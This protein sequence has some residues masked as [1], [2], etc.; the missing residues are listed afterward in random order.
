MSVPDAPIITSI[1]ASYKQLSVYFTPPA[2]NGGTD[3]TAYSYTINNRPYVSVSST[4]SPIDISGLIPGLTYTVSLTCTNAV[5]TSIPSAPV[6]A[7]L[8][9]T[10]SFEKAM[11]LETNGE[12]V[13]LTLRNELNQTN[14]YK[15]S[16]DG[17]HWTGHTFPI[18]GLTKYNPYNSKWTGSHF[19][20]C[21]DITNL[22]GKDAILK[23]TDG[24]EFAP[25]ATNTDYPMFDIETNHEHRNTITF[26]VDT[27]LV[28]G[29]VSGDTVQLAHTHDLGVSWESASPSPFSVSANA[30]CW[31]GS[32]W[33]AVGTGTNTIA[34]SRID[35][36]IWTGCGSYIFS[37]SGNSVAWSKEQ[38]LIV[39]VGSGINS[40]AYSPDGLYWFGCGSSIFS[41]GTSVAWN[42]NIWVAV[43]TGGSA[44]IAY[45][46]NGKTWVSSD[47]VFASGASLVSW[48][49]TQW[50]VYG[51]DPSYNIATSADGIH[52]TMKS[53]P[54]FPS[55]KHISN[56]TG[57][58]RISGSTVQ[59]SFDGIVWT[60]TTPISGMSSPKY[61]A[62]NNST[63]GIPAISP[64]TVAAGEGANTL[65]YSPDGIFWTGTQSRVFSVRANSAVWNGQIWVAVGTGTCSIATSYDGISWTPVYNSDA[66]LTEIYDVAWNGT[67]FVAVG[68]STNQITMAV[69][70]DGKT[71]STISQSVFSIRASGIAWTGRIWVAYG[72]GG[73][74]TAIS[75]DVYAQTWSPTSL[76]I[77][78]A[79]NLPVSNPSATITASSFSTDHQPINAFNQTTAQSWRSASSTYSTMT[80]KYVGSNSTTVA[81]G[82]TI[83][84]EWIQIQFPSPVILNYSCITC[85]L[86]DPSGSIPK[87][88]YIV[89]SNDGTA[90]D[91]VDTHFST[92][93]VSPINNSIYVYPSSLFYN[94]T[95]YVYYRLVCASSFGATHVSI[96][97]W[98]LFSKT[99]GSD[100][101][102]LRMKPIIT[103]NAI[104]YASTLLSLDN[105]STKLQPI[106]WTSLA[107]TVYT[108][109][110]P[111]S[112]QTYI[113]RSLSGI[114]QPLSATCF[115]GENVICASISGDIIYASPN[116]SNTTYQFDQS[117]NQTTIQSNLSTIY[118]LCYNTRFIIAGG[119]S[120][121]YTCMKPGVIP[122][123]YT[124]NASNIMSTVYCV[125]SNSGYGPTYIPNAIYL[126]TGE[127]LSV[128]SPKTYNPSFAS[129]TSIS[130][131]MCKPSI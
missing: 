126:Q 58:F 39:A 1:F 31:T 124:T 103:K 91:L 68:E 56:S 123:W 40:I 113:L 120:I 104:L 81:L 107:N 16:N 43:G 77:N 44:S 34:V 109:D 116:H 53:A 3:I 82:P 21:G 14:Q 22:D 17:I 10:Y 75:T 33:V 94:T 61:I 128:V 60:N 8:A 97:E 73:N 35:P 117:F 7:F 111:L 99:V 83:S 69:S 127:K 84:G 27:I 12:T 9:Y 122:S 62:W 66:L 42:G 50:V 63:T 6:S 4:T 13:L 65:A 23:S 52:W 115:D 28:M 54:A 86:S 49:T 118:S 96:T 57:L 72:S 93:A 98:S 25:T 95:S 11:S 130:I 92:S 100:I 71:W 80:G 114:S 15:T 67:V 78:T 105:G 101:L 36:V 51:T 20:V 131:D 30:A 88:W 38:H 24:T 47:I 41:V 64:I 55:P 2:N 46:I 125:A 32:L 37:Q 29:G 70:L 112:S 106:V 119:S 26:P 76:V 48:Q 102:P 110:T 87:Q 90:W 59:T 18:T 129:N 121:T 85:S 108:S 79:I 19:I 89:A 74:T 45:S 5:G